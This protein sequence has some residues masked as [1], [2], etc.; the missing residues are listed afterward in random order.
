[1]DANPRI[2]KVSKNQKVCNP[3][4]KTDQKPFE[5]TSGSDPAIQYLNFHIK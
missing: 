3:G 5:G 2:Y 4:K 1:V